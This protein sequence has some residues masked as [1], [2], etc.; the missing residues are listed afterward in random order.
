M[1]VCAGADFDYIVVGAGSAGCVLADRLSA[2]GEHRVLVLEAGG[3]DLSF[4][5]RM[6]IGYGKVYYDARFNW[7]YL[8]EPEEALGGKPSYW[9]RGK[10]LGGSSSINA[11]VYAR[12]H[13]GDFDDWAADGA[14][15]WDWGSVA[16]YFK[17]M[18]D[19]AGGADERRGAGGPLPVADIRGEVHS[20]CQ[21]FLQA[22]REAHLPVTEDYNGVQVEGA[23]IYQITTK[24]GLRASAAR[25]YLKPAMKRVNVKVL[26]R[27]HATR[28]VMEDGR[29][30]G[31]AFTRGGETRVVR[32]R[33]EV[34]VSGGAINSPQLLQLSGIGPG[35]VL[36]PLGI[37]VRR[38]APSIGRNLQDHLGLDMHYR[39]TVPTLNQVLR[40]WWGKLRAGL[41]FLLL[42]RG[43]LTL[44]VNQGGG[45]V[46]TRQELTRPNLQLY[47]SPVSYTRAP[48]GE[49]PMMSPDDFPGFLLGFSSCRPTSRGSIHIRS[50]DPFAA[51]E[52]R[53]NYL[54]TQEDRAAML[55]GARFIRR[56]AATPAMRSVIETEISPGPHAESDEDIQAHIR[57]NAWTV[58][59][60]SCTCRMGSDPET[61]TVDPRLRVHGV[62]GLRVVDASV[63]PSVTSGNTNAPTI[64]VA[65]RAADLILEDAR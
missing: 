7:K 27:A 40:P 25:C 36:Q 52:I 8:S 24:N 2:S 51:P 45:F 47:F 38:D 62:E 3:S 19:W 41:Q 57:D 50:A 61:S 65:E 58:F 6:P 14:T 1:K 13:P 46:R 21:N 18:E 31:V 60:A 35:E 9:P 17:R 33:R 43:P 15:G 53:P 16:P 32:A 56:L 63:F 55:E 11:L 42:R 30:V 4:W 23:S 54:S 20:L 49:R 10:V 12:G 29:A 37:E 34:I 48:P 26:T 44:S 22:A 64:M 39:A 59:H 28:I 5:I